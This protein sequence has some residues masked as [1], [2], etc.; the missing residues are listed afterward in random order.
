M[1]VDEA[2]GSILVLSGSDIFKIDM[3]TPPVVSDQAVR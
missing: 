1:A 2:G 3:G